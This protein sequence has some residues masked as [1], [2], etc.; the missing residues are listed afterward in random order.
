M[1]RILL[2]LLLLPLGGCVSTH[3]C[4]NQAIINQMIVWIYL[5]GPLEKTPET[6]ER[7]QELPENWE[8]WE[9]SEPN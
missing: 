7:F 5:H 9:P 6:Q 3:R 2:S 4:P 8:S 1:K